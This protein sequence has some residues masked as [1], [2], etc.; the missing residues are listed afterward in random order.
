[1]LQR[2]PGGLLC[3]I[4]T[5]KNC[6]A[7]GKRKM[8]NHTDNNRELLK[9][10]FTGIGKI[11]NLQD[12]V[13]TDYHQYEKVIDFEK[14]LACDLQQ[15]YIKFNAN[16]LNGPIL[17]VQRPNFTSAPAIPKTLQE[18]IVAEKWKDFLQTPERR[19][20]IQRDQEVEK[21]EEDPSRI[22]IWQ[23][24]LPEREAWAEGAK[25]LYQIEKLFQTLYQL[26]MMQKQDFDSKE[27]VFA[28]GLF[29]TKATNPIHISHPLFTKKLRIS[30]AKS[31]ENIIEVFD[32]GE[33]LEVETSFFQEIQ[34]G[35]VH[36][37]AQIGENFLRYEDTINIYKEA[38]LEP[39]LKDVLSK[40]TSHG[41]Y[42][43]KEQLPSARIKSQRPYLLSYSP[44]ILYRSQKSGIAAFLNKII[45]DVDK[46]GKIKPHLIDIM[47]PQ[48]TVSNST[49]ISGDSESSQ[50]I[51]KRLNAISGEDE[52]S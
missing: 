48:D 14:Y 25:R 16:S 15:D 33:N 52:K 46:N 6:F 9:N 42:C 19:E 26:N 20:Q 22:R 30:D 11:I 31:E 40:I 41:D 23:K 45:E 7:E 51:G 35:S 49:P 36:Q 44:L 43:T 28:F 38:T 27:L 13:I 1:M 29:E 5:P 32:T 17:T 2:M 8:G 34:D 21:F 18:W 12:Q 3:S 50:D 4:R 37:I 24:L 39:A 10:F 47:N